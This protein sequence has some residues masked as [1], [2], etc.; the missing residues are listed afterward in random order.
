MIWVRA[1]HQLEQSIRRPVI[2]GHGGDDRLRQDIERVLHDLGGLDIARAHG[3]DDRRDL[4]GIIPKRRHQHTPAL[5]AERVPRAPDAL[6]G[7]AYPL[8]RLQLQHQID[9][10][11]VDP[12][13][14]RARGDQGAQRAGLERGLQPE[15]PLAGERSVIRLR[16]L[17]FG[18]RVHACRDAF[19]LCAVVDEHQCRP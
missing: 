13:L 7:R 8:R 19:R 17:L 10:A 12:Q 3:R 18:E 9:R 5:G 15:A 1:A 6:Q 2:D 4:H 11:D 14:E 16:D